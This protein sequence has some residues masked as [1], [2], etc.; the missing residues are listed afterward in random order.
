M[1]VGVDGCKF[2]VVVI[3]GRGRRESVDVVYIYGVSDEARKANLWRFS[4]DVI[5]GWFCEAFQGPFEQ[6]LGC[7]RIRFSARSLSGL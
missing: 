2:H 6:T 3:F 1:T 4:V 5:R 7:G